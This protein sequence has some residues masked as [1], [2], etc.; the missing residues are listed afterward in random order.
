MIFDL[1]VS[2]GVVGVR[3]DTERIHAVGICVEMQ[4]FEEIHFIDDRFVLDLGIAHEGNAALGRQ[5]G[6]FIGEDSDGLVVLRGLHV[7]VSA[8]QRLPED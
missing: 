4:R 2:P 6:L 7:T 3:L 5:F 8:M 1:K